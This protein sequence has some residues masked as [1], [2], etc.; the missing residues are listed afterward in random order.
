M[1]LG[2]GCIVG[3]SYVESRAIDKGSDVIDFPKPSHDG[4]G[5]AR[6][7]GAVEAAPSLYGPAS[8]GVTRSVAS[9]QYDE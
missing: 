6:E 4:T 8:G 1:C 5:A 3:E 9:R 7:E 2:D